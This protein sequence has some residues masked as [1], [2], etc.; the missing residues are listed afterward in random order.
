MSNLNNNAAQKPLVGDSPTSANLLTRQ[1]VDFIFLTF[2]E[3]L[4]YIK[5]VP[6]KS[7]HGFDS[8]VKITAH[9]R[10]LC[11]FFMCNA[12]A[13]PSMGEPGG[14]AHALPVPVIS[15]LSTCSVS[16]TLLTGGDVTINVITGGHDNV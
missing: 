1:R 10:A 16:L 12:S 13:C 3:L 8:S 7:G 6:A 9:N 4:G 14:R 11:G 5:T 15:G 2:S